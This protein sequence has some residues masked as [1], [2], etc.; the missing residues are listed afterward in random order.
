MVKNITNQLQKIKKQN[1]LNDNNLYVEKILNFL[2]DGKGSYSKNIK[3]SALKS[4]ANINCLI[5]VDGVLNIEILLNKLVIYKGDINNELNI[6]FLLNINKENILEFNVINGNNNYSQTTISILGYLKNINKNII[7]L[8]SFDNTFYFLNNNKLSESTNI[9]S[10]FNNYNDNIIDKYDK[11]YDVNQVI[12]NDINYTFAIYKDNAVYVKN[13]LSNETSYLFEKVDDVCLFSSCDSE[14]NYII[15]YIKNGRIFFSKFNSNFIK[16]ND[17]C[18]DKI[19]NKNYIKI[20]SVISD[21][22][23]NYLLAQDINHMWYILKFDISANEIVAIKP[24]T[25]CD[26]LQTYQYNN[27]VIFFR[28]NNDGVIVEKY[29]EWSLKNKT[30]YEEFL[31]ATDGYFYNNK[32][33]LVNFNF[34]S[35]LPIGD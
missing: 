23:V 13:I 32:L 28:L 1:L 22:N 12:V 24:Y 9:S 21:D 35:E 33:Y 4:K 26:D 2:I 11:I 30:Y 7:K 17:V 20:K 16:I 6:N 15:F 25:K 19:W 18:F 34:V 3:F 5:K 10:S 29:T 31:N 8:I 14:N 27:F